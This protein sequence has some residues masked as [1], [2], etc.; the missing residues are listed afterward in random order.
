MGSSLALDQNFLCMSFRLCDFFRI[1]FHVTKDSSLHFFWY[2]ATERM[3]KKSQRVPSFRFF[4]TL[5][6][7]KIL[8]FFCKIFQ[9]SL[10]FFEILQQNGCLKSL[11]VPLFYIFRHYENAFL[12]FSQHAIT[13]FFNTGVLSMQVFSNSF[14]SKSPLSFFLRNEIFC[15]H[16]GLL[17]HYATFKKISE[18]ISLYF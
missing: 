14:L 2:F 12:R 1:F 10:Q 9:V 16:R 17:G 7:L 8:C 13:E 3:L 6:L 11:K 18:K 15:E 5:R 4:G